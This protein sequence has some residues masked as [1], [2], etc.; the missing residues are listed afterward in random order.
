MSN[1][2]LYKNLEI[3]FDKKELKTFCRVSSAKYEMLYVED[4]E[5]KNLPSENLYEFEWWTKKGMEL[6]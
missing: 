3:I 5:N 1:E 2:Q 6:V 4:Y